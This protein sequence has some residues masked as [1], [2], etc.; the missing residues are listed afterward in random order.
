MLIGAL[1]P[2]EQQEDPAFSQSYVYDADDEIQRVDMRLGHLSLGSDGPQ[3]R[4]RY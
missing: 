2:G 4:E 3:K 1:L